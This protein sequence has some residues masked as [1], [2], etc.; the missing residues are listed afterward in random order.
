MAYTALVPFQNGLKWGFKNLAG[1]TQIEPLYDMASPF[2]N[3]ISIVIKEGKAGLLAAS[4]DY[5]LEPV[6]DAIEPRDDLGMYH[7]RENGKTGMVSYSGE[8]LSPAVFDEVG[9][10][11]EGLFPALKENCWGFYNV[12]MQEVIPSIYT[13]AK[14]FR[15]G[16]AEVT[17]LIGFT[18]LIDR[19]NNEVTTPGVVYAGEEHLS[20]YSPDDLDVMHWSSIRY[21]KYREAAM[22]SSGGKLLFTF[23]YKLISGKIYELYNACGDGYFITGSWPRAEFPQSDDC[24]RYGVINARGDQMLP[25]IFEHLK[26]LGSDAFAF[27]LD[28][29]WGVIN[30]RLEVLVEPHFNYPHE[31]EGGLVVRRERASLIVD[32]WGDHPN[33][34]EVKADL[35]KMDFKTV[36][37]D[38]ETAFY[39]KMHA[40]DPTIRME[41]MINYGDGSRSAPGLPDN[42]EPPDPHFSHGLISK[43]ALNETEPAGFEIDEDMHERVN[44]D[45][46]VFALE[47]I[48]RPEIWM[49]PDDDKYSYRRAFDHEITR[50]E[51]FSYS[52]RDERVLVNEARFLID[53]NNDECDCA[54]L[55]W[56]D[57]RTPEEPSPGD[58]YEDDEDDEEYEEGGYGEYTGEPEY[59]DDDDFE[60][61]L[62][63]EE[64]EAEP[65]TGQEAGSKESTTSYYGAGMLLDGDGKPS[66]VVNEDTL[67]KWGDG[68]YFAFSR[69]KSFSSATIRNSNFEVI[70]PGLHPVERD[71]WSN[72]KY[73]RVSLAG[74]Y[75]FIDRK[76]RLVLDPVFKSLSRFI[77]GTAIGLTEDAAVVIDESFNCRYLDIEAVDFTSFDGETVAIAIDG[78]EGVKWG[79]ITTSGEEVLPFRYRLLRRISREYILAKQDGMFGVIN[80]SGTEVLPFVYTGYISPTGRYLPLISNTGLFT[81]FNIRKGKI[82]DS[83]RTG[84]HRHHLRISGIKRLNHGYHVLRLEKETEYINPAAPPRDT[85]I[86]ATPPPDLDGL[87]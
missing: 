16:I 82:I 39:E 33:R 15:C 78:S 59:G 64:E 73:F 25:L 27:K 81:L 49:L 5:I 48:E 9:E 19:Q 69:E 40:I 54:D 46:P 84:S 65:E 28:A 38:G 7:F 60:R 4:G 61:L 17:D 83:F 63:G 14:K 45:G 24:L 41:Y 12:R 58:G 35:L 42:C 70:L 1:K 74:K 8:T 22:V 21:G 87:I 44:F 76:G 52:T 71:K 56:A 10:L 20:R 67:E 80:N 72:D 26:Y 11:S 68:V 47:D 43:A 2:K 13:S 31:L 53:S 79:L 86:M 77:K 57:E 66:A 85:R 3:G 23:D 29:K 50:I 75:G 37:F 18:I 34:E 36:R 51:S 62:R 32:T 6:Y 55:E 30:T